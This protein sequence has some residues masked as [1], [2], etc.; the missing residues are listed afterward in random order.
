MGSGHRQEG[1]FLAYRACL[2][3]ANPLRGIGGPGRE[4]RGLREGWA[5]YATQA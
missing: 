3:E 2:P 1:P 5:R 4:L